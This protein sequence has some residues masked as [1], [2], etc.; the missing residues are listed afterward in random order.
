[1]KDGNYTQQ[2]PD[3]PRTSM[4]DGPSDIRNYWEHLDMNYSLFLR[5]GSL[6]ITY[7]N[8][9]RNLTKDSYPVPSNPLSWIFTHNSH[10]YPSNDIKYEIIEAWHTIKAF[11]EL[12]DKAKQENRFVLTK[13]LEQEGLTEEVFLTTLS[14][15]SKF[16]S[17][18]Y[19]IK[20]SPHILSIIEGASHNSIPAEE[21]ILGD[22]DL[23]NNKIP[24][25]PCGIIIDNSLS[26]GE[27]GVLENLQ[28]SLK[29]LSAEIAKSDELSKCIEL[30]VTTCGGGPKVI[31]EYNLIDLQKPVLDNLCLTPTGPCMMAETIE[32]T[33]DELKKRQDKWTRHEIC[34]KT[35]NI[36]IM[37]DGY[38]FRGDM[39]HAIKRLRNE[40]EY[41]KVF[42]FGV[43]KKAN[44]RNLSEISPNTELLGDLTGFFK[45]VF[46]SQERITMSHEGGYRVNI[47]GT[48]TFTT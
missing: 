27:D 42:V 29:D 31:A 35:P 21:A 18:A 41:V 44:I 13:D 45:D 28:Q 32:K 7:C 20:I 37:S 30:Y 1:M 23:I 43:S 39:K 10:G 25:F 33:L 40:F 15:V 16:F 46:N 5:F 38:N 47:I 6:S 22:D 14:R 4:S 26:M 9:I 11:K 48:H 2:L 34:I 17:W 19:G 3:G 24:R 12:R 8:S 36:I